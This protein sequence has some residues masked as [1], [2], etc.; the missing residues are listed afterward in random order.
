MGQSKS[1]QLEGRG[2]EKLAN[3]EKSNNDAP[4]F[5]DIDALVKM[6]PEN[7]FG[8][9]LLEIDFSFFKELPHKAKIRG[10]KFDTTNQV[11]KHHIVR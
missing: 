9:I 11:W 7:N 1:K 5:S 4:D 6:N 2:A 3:E 8:Q 10:I